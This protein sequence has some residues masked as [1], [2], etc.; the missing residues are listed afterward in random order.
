MMKKYFIIIG[1]FIS[2]LFFVGCRS[3]AEKYDIN[4]DVEV[5]T[6][7][8]YNDLQELLEKLDVYREKYIS[9][10]LKMTKESLNGVEE[11]EY[12]IKYSKE[13]NVIN[14]I[15]SFDLKNYS[16]TKYIKDN[17]I[18][19]NHDQIAEPVKSTI[20]IAATYNFKNLILS[21]K[22]YK[23]ILDGFIKNISPT[24]PNF[25]A[26]YDKEENIVVEYITKDI[27]FRFVFNGTKPIYLHASTGNYSYDYKFSYEKPK[28]NKPKGF[29]EDDYKQ[30]PWKDFIALGI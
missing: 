15:A 14:A 18:Y 26:G 7:I 8:S 16:Y 9:M 20:A 10:E 24:S 21:D 2:C 4:K 28:I 25:I 17:V 1:L 29:K 3:E 12:E 23:D 11:L 5:V 13:Q 6:K 27:K 22:D 30:I 19:V